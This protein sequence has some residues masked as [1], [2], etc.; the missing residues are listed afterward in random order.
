MSTAKICLVL[1]LSLLLAAAGQVAIGLA[2][3]ENPAKEAKLLSTETLRIMDKGV[4]CIYVGEEPLYVLPT[5]TKITNK[6]GTTISLD[7]LL[8]PCLAE[9]TYAR[10][11]K[12]VNKLPV[13]V[14]LK[15]KKE[16]HNATAS[17]SRER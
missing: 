16:Y 9:V 3:Q 5:V 8:T 10:W 7:R 4:D 13:V 12:G 11:M 14:E 1:A 15:V 6:Y 2:G 17:G